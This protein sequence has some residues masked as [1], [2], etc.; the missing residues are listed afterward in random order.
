MN[1][2]VTVVG[3]LL[4]S[5]IGSI[6]ILLWIFRKD[7]KDVFGKKKP[8]YRDERR[9]MRNHI[10]KELKAIAFYGLT[11]KVMVCGNGIHNHILEEDT[12]TIMPDDSNFPKDAPVC[13]PLCFGRHWIYSS[14]LPDDKICPLSAWKRR[15]SSELK[16][17][18]K[19]SEKKGKKK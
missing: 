7:V 2:I 8:S 19:G 5:S 18:E 10:F 12:I 14:L 11:E 4:G 16:G 3:A 9:A 1:I 17:L 13:A 15:L 6:M